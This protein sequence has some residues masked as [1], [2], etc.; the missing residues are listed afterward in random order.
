MTEDKK[1]VLEDESDL[2]EKEGL[3][4]DVQRRWVDDSARHAIRTI[5]YCLIRIAKDKWYSWLTAGARTNYKEMGLVQS[6]ICVFTDKTGNI[7]VDMWVKHSIFTEY[8]L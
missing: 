4:Q 5:T 6:S 7:N 2:M 8:R 3:P 1:K